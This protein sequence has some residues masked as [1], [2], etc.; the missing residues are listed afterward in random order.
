MITNLSLFPPEILIIILPLTASLIIFSLPRYANSV[1]LLS[2]VIIAFVIYWLVIGIIDSGSRSL[3]L[4]GWKP[5]LGILLKTD[6]FSLLMIIM[7][8]IVAIGVGVYAVNYFEA[9]KCAKFW[10][11]WL[12]LWA[13]LNALFISNDLFNFYITIELIGIAA[14]SLTAL[15]DKVEGISA[16][17]RYLLLALLGSLFYLLGV[18]IIYHTYHTLDITLLASKVVYDHLTILAFSF[19]SIGLALKSALFPLHFWLPTAHASAPAPVSAILSA[20]VVK[21]SLFIFVRFSLD[22]FKVDSPLYFILGMLGSFAVLWGAFNALQQSRLKLII[23]Y[24][25]IAQVGYLFIALYF[26]TKAG[27]AGWQAFVCI[28]MAHACAKAAMFLAAG[29]LIRSGGSDHLE[30]LDRTVHRHPITT[31]AFAIAGISI[32][33]LPISGGFVGKWFLLDAALNSNEWYFIFVII[34]GGLFAAGYV[35]KVLGQTFY[36]SPIAKEKVAVPATMEWAA[37]FLAIASILV[38]IYAMPLFK[39]VSIGTGIGGG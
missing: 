3:Y 16:T 25:T 34:L 23:A 9:E 11:L 39:L 4:G 36:E 17:L 26:T 31:A 1:G 19:I 38:G 29:N 8:G 10:R 35:F 27:A 22:L 7:T 13:S 30:S 24:S 18:V 20:L 15:S 33:G 21:A 5:P 14:V 28:L 2:T 32:V 6:G 12:V 37:L